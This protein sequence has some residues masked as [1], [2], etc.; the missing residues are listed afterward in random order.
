MATFLLV[1]KRRRKRPIGPLCLM[2]PIQWYCRRVFCPRAKPPPLV[3]APTPAL[4]PS[5]TRSAVPRPR[6]L[7]ESHML[8]PPVLPDLPSL[9]LFIILPHTRRRRTPALHAQPQ[10]PKL[11]DHLWMPNSP[12]SS[13]S[14]SGTTLEEPEPSAGKTLHWAYLMYSHKVSLRRLTNSWSTSATTPR[15]PKPQV[16]MASSDQVTIL[17]LHRGAN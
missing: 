5:A 6:P 7:T 8:L 12:P 11:A 13:S 9:L 15:I 4:H 3:Q 17:F 14:S 16:N 2:G 10:G 1:M